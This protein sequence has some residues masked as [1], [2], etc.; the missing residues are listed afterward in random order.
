M[1]NVEAKEALPEK[2]EVRDWPAFKTGLVEDG[3]ARCRR[4]RCLYIHRYFY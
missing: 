2:Y 3:T 4:N 1:G